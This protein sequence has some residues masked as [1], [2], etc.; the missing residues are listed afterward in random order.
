[1][2]MLE[3]EDGTEIYYKD[4][5]VGRP[6][7]FHHA[8]P[9]S[10]DEWDPQLAFFLQRGFRVIAHDRRGHGRSTQTSFGN[11][12]DTYAADVAEL[13]AHLDLRNAVHI[14]HS[15]GGGEAA[16]YIARHG[17][18]RVS[19]AVLLSSVCPVVLKSAETP[20]GVPVD[21]LDQVREGVAL[22]RAQMFRELSVPYYGYNRPDANVSRAVLNNWWRQGMMGGIKAQVDC[23]RAFSETDFTEDLRQIG[24]P[25]FV[26]QGDDDQC[27]PYLHAQKA[28]KL[29]PK[30]TLKIY[31]GLP[32]GMPMTNAEQINRDLLTFIQAS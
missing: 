24:V 17:T 9:L 16:R 19:K 15:T 28:A 8:F 4:W 6:I 13:V 14:G 22:N 1:M 30:S 5:G 12:M 21:L 25:T 23:I 27:V 2:S 3:V 29:L 20:D 31:A 11:D 32:H 7:M 18:G 26:M 10:S